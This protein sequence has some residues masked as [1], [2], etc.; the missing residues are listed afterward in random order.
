MFN[1]VVKFLD[2]SKLFFLSVFLVSLTFAN[3]FP[4]PF[5][6]DPDYYWHLMNGELILSNG[7]IPRTDP[8]S[9]TA[10]DRPWVIHEW[11]FEVI[12]FVLYDSFG[13]LAVQA[14]TL[15][16]AFAS[17][18]V[19][20]LNAGRIL[21]RPV[22]LI[23]LALL[24][25]GSVVIFATPRPH[26]FSYVFFGLFLY[27]MFS[28]KYQG[29]ERQLFL[30]PLIMVLW[31]N[32]HGGFMIGIAMLGLFTLGEMITGIAKFE[33]D[34]GWRRR[35]ILLGIC[36]V[37]T[38]LASML[39]PDGWERLIHPFEVLGSDITTSIAEWRSP[40]F[41]NIQGRV[42]LLGVFTFFVATAFREK[43]PDFTEL[44]VPCFFI[45]AGFTSIRHE[46]FA[47][48]TILPF[49]AVALQAGAMTH[50][51]ALWARLY[52]FR[53]PGS[54]R[55]QAELGDKI[56]VLNWAVLGVLS[57]S[58]SLISIL[59]GRPTEFR[60][61]G[62]LPIKATRFVLESGLQGRMFN[63][64]HYGGYLIKQLYPQQ[65]VF[66]DGRSELYGPEFMRAYRITES[67]GEGWDATIDKY[68]IDYAIVRSETAIRQLLLARGDFHLVYQD[69][70][71]SVVVRDEPRYAELIARFARKVGKE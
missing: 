23:F 40:D 59:G 36:T 14:L 24:C 19:A 37:A 9:Y 58:L 22:L 16:L 55:L 64:Y 34:S 52:S 15:G 44:A 70:H 31:V 48:L 13:V 33:A 38:V 49:T 30:L 4:S 35:V 43:K 17:I 7:G 53:L 62:L 68:S 42:Y 47:V 5:L 69:E 21:N 71:T 28:L 18:Y 3:I 39:N 51:D 50:L 27:A 66:I 65:K 63:T 25:S 10:G 2:I 60:D 61:T 57:L 67:G 1:K 12:L 20:V 26:L 8:F 45:L 56:Y 46:P 41:S 54:G 11:L 6:E 29:K 32:L